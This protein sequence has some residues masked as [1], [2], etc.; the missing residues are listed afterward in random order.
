MS[1]MN[2]RQ[3]H[4]IKLT[5]SK[6]GNKKKQMEISHYNPHC[7]ISEKRVWKLFSIQVLPTKYIE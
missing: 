4:T 3:L 2:S 5:H 1:N 6:N 7:V